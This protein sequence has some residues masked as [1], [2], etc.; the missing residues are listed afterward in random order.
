MI[1]SQQAMMLDTALA[2]EKLIKKPKAGVKKGQEL[3]VQ[4]SCIFWPYVLPVPMV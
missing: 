3:G 2:F 1:P 4:V